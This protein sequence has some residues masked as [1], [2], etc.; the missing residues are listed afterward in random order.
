[1]R[2]AAAGRAALVRR[3]HVLMPKLCRRPQAIHAAK[4][5]LAVDVTHMEGYP[6]LTD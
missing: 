5:L 3:M 2:R 4:F 6:H 1:M